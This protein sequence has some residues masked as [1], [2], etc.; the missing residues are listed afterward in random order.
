MNP[1]EDTL[2][3]LLQVTRR[4]AGSADLT[5]SAFGELL[6]RRGQLIDRLTADGF[7]PADARLQSIV[8]DGAA[9]QARMRSRRDSLREEI[10]GLERAAVMMD[11]MKATLLHTGH[12]VDLVA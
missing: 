3:E 6:K 2:S 12:A 5:D 7:D 1:S 8:L 9:L 11:G 4:L 10:A